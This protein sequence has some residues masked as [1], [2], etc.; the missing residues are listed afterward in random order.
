MVILGIDIGGNQLRAGMV[1]GEGATLASR[2]I[3]TPADLDTFVA[4]LREVI[5][6]L[7]ET[8]GMPAGAGV[9]CKGVIDPESTMVEQLPGTLHYLQGLR[10]SEV[11]PLPADVPVFADNDARA[12]LSGEVVWGAA[13]DLRDVVMLNLSSTVGGAALIDGKL[14]RGSRGMA[15]MLGHITVEPDGAICACGNRGCLQTVFSAQ[16]IESEAWAAVHRGC[17]SVLTRLFREQPQLATYRTVLGAAGEGDAV[18]GAVVDRATRRLGAA[19][20]GLIHI[21]DPEAVILGGYV[22]DAGRDLFEPLEQDVWDRSRVLLGREV[23]LL[24]AQIADG[25]GIAG[26][27]ALVMAPRP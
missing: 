20:A 24:R 5:R 10:I 1:D 11:L 26:A 8:S 25:S 3:Q 18:A 9:G 17:D 15:G 2:T 27:A 19:I 16:A 6:W 7:V 4:S 13:R 14:M 12:A 21:F 22:A 23:P